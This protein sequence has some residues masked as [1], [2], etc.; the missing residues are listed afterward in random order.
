MNQKK[1][2]SFKKTLF[3]FIAFPLFAVNDVRQVLPKYKDENI[4]KAYAA[5][6]EQWNKQ[7]QLEWEKKLKQ[8]KKG[9]ASLVSAF[10]SGQIV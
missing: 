3:T 6:E 8:P 7:Q 1:K 5:W 2:E 10:S 4:P 9:L